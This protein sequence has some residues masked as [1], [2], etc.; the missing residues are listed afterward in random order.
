M[1]RPFYESEED[2]QNERSLADLVEFKFN[3]KLTKMSIKYRLD[4]I[5]ER[6]GKAVAF[7]EMRHRKNKM[8][9]FPTYMMSLAKI[10]SAAS[11]TDTTG[12]PCFLAV[13]WSDLAGMCKIPSEE[14]SVSVGGSYRRNDPQ[15]IEPMVYIPMSQFKTMERANGK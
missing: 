10:Q 2:R 7:F 13:Q 8:M 1:S 14:F 15:D 9:A 6:D 5:A 11:L 12:L 3:C 4:Y